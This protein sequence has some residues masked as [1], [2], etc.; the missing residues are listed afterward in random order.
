MERMADRRVNLGPWRL[1]V[2]ADFS[3]RRRGQAGLV[4]AEV[5]DEAPYRTPQYE[6]WLRSVDRRRAREIRE[7][8]GK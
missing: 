5:V 4:R 3:L 8:L 7:E 1:V 6:A 2:A